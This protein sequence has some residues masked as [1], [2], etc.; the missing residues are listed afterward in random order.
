MGK[1]NVMNKDMK[2]KGRE[3]YVEYKKISLVLLEGFVGK[4]VFK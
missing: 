1:R 2:V 4:F 3:I